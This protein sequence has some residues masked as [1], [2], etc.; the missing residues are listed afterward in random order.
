MLK[1]SDEEAKFELFMRLNTGGSKLEPQEIRNCL[2]IMAHPE[3]YEWIRELSMVDEFLNAISV[4][5]RSIEEKY[6]M[7]LVTRFL[8]FRKLPDN[9]LSAVGDIGEF[10]NS[11][12]G[13]IDNL[14][15]AKEKS[16]RS[17][18]SRNIPL[19]LQPA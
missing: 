16:G 12:L 15:P 17:S 7:E 13:L 9:E 18:I 3:M 1:E 11:N 8:M 5:D 2:M 19:H 6:H 14:K 10:L 4:S